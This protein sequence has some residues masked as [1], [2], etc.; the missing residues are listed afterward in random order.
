M[1]V[2]AVRTRYGITTSIME[3][4]RRIGLSKIVNLLLT[5][6]KTVRGTK[7][8]MKIDANCIDR[9]AVKIIEELTVGIYDGLDNTKDYDVF[10]AMTLAHIRGVIDMATALKNV[11][12]KTA[13]SDE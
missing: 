10:G 4:P 8:Y 7:K 3:Q 1:I 13:V 5:S 6:R 11:L 2:Q 9:E 12:N